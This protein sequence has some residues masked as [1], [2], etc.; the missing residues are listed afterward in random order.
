MDEFLSNPGAQC[1]LFPFLD[2]PSGSLPGTPACWDFWFNTIFVHTRI[3][4]A[5]CTSEPPTDALLFSRF[6]DME[7]QKAACCEYAKWDQSAGINPYLFAYMGQGL[8]ICISVLGAAWG[9]WITGT[10]LVGAAI[11]VPR[12]RSKNLIS[13]I[14][15]EAT[16]IYGII[17]AI[18]MNTK[19]GTSP[20]GSLD[21]WTSEP[22]LQAGQAGYALFA[23]GCCV[24]FSNLVCGVCV[25]IAGSSCA[26]ADAQNPVLFVKILVVEI[27]GSALGLFGVI[28]G[29]IMLPTNGLAEK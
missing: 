8:A 2:A 29:I 1:T 11:R 13:I 3:T 12:I 6:G 9:I 14:F 26:L 21:Q 23:A 5:S 20:A 7:D 10:S 15:C 28:M 27:F 4:T 18:I 16:A 24:G 25:G 17:M 22:L 19:L